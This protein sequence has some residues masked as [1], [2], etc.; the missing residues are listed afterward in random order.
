MVHV[1]TLIA[2][3][4]VFWRDIREIPRGIRAIFAGNQGTRSF[5]SALWRSSQG[6]LVLLIVVGSVPAALMGF[7]FEEILSHLFAS[8][9]FA[10][11]MLILTGT[12][13]WFTRRGPSGSKGIHEM[14]VIDA[15]TVGLGQGFSL[16]PGISRSGITISLGLFRGM[17]REWSGKF[18]FLLA[19][20]AILGA[21]LMEFTM[22]SELSSEELFSVGAGTV[23]AIVVGYLSLRT[24]MHVVK[25]GN[26]AAF[27]YYCWG[28]GALTVF[29]FM[30]SL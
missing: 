26:L 1:G 9:L 16:I 14:G 29:L 15:L 2:I 24:L 5:P 13:L 22:P 10:G 23:V 27:A 6:R 21:L 7:F 28:A 3:V 18:S 30:S 17:E 25:R 20:P 8:P 11:L 19:I 12:I 4:I